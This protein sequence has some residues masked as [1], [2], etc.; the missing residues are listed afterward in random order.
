MT[1]V[2]GYA[3]HVFTA[4]GIAFMFLAAAELCAPAPDARWVFLWF[5]LATLVDAL[6]G[7]L[8][9]RWH[10]KTTAPQI[11]G[12]TIDDI[13]DYLGFTFLPLLMTWRLGW[14]PD[15]IGGAV[16]V[17]AMMASLLGFAHKHAKDEAAGFFRGFPSYWNLAVF[18]FGWAAWFAPNVG[19]WFNAA[20][21]LAL[22]VLTILPVWVP[23]PNLAPAK[24]KPLVL[25]GSYAW[26][27]VLLAMIP[28]YPRLPAWL[29]I[30][31]LV[32]PIFTIWLSWHLRPLWPAAK[33]FDPADG[34]HASDA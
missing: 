21:V 7:P 19:P 20:V 32:Y 22:A 1:A 17:V 2:K 18:Y 23:Y 24:W 9:R 33:R 6:D 26:A 10:V 3:V 5:L 25:W 28:W 16:V 14:V 30:A 8:A 4:S 15:L 29:V 13:V 31:T 34:V 11:S 27:V 12:R